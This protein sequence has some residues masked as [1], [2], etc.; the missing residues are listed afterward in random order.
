MPYVKLSYLII[1][2]SYSNFSFGQTIEE[3]KSDNDAIAFLKNNFPALDSF[4]YPE[5]TA[6]DFSENKK[7]DV[8][9]FDKNGKPDLLIAGTIDGA[10]NLAFVI[11]AEGNNQ[12]KLNDVSP[13]G[14]YFTPVSVIKRIGN[15][16][17]IL[18]QQ[19][20]SAKKWSDTLIYKYGVF[21][22]YKSSVK[23]RKISMLHY[24]STGC[25]GGCP[26]YKIMLDNSLNATLEATKSRSPS[27]NPA[28]SLQGTYY[29]KLTPEKFNELTELTNYIDLP[30][31]DDR[32]SVSKTGQPTGIIEI[33][34]VDGSFKRI[35]DYGKVG[36][37]ALRV[38]HENLENLRFSQIW[39][40][41]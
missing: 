6:S 23:Q 7:W 5:S 40:S 32:Y 33:V 24:G 15:D 34:F 20:V 10:K 1:L 19:S 11:L 35:D 12:Y 3:I 14:Y 31:L 41:N 16:N 37:P 25:Q 38:F 27:A 13:G 17:V 22:K 39:K 36:T 8:A 9:D 2:F 18:L 26:V 4:R 29:S 21:L 30:S 28:D